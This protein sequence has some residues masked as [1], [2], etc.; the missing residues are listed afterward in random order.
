MKKLILF[1][2]AA[3]LFA[4]CSSDNDLVQQEQPQATQAS[5]A[6]SFNAYLQR[7]TTTRAGWVGGATSSGLQSIS[8]L[9]AEGFGVFAYYT[10]NFDYT[11]LYLPNF[12][13]NEKV[14]WST[15]P[16]PGEFR[17][18]TTKYW[19]N[20]HGSAAKSVDQDR[21]SFFA[22]LPY[23]DTDP[24]TGF[25]KNVDT[26]DPSQQWGITGMKRNSM[27][28]D[29]VIQ[30]ITSFDQDKSV[31]LCWGTTG[32][33]N[34]TWS[35]NS[36]TQTIT[37]GKPWLN[38]RKP[39]GVV[40]NNSKVNFTFLHA[41]SKFRVTVQTDNTDS[42]IATDEA[43]ATRVWIRSI[44]FTGIA[45]KAALNLNNPVANK[46]R[47]IDYYGS[48][49]LEMGESVTVYDGRKDG[50][51]GV[52]G[53]E[54]VSETVLGLNPNLIQDEKQLTSSG[55]L[56][57]GT[58]YHTGVPSTTA[59]NLFCNGTDPADVDD[60]IFVIPT[61]EKVDVEIVYD[62]ETIDEKLPVYLSDS[63]THGSSV[64][65]RIT[66]KSVFA[67]L[68]NGKSYVLNLK[69]G[70]KDV[71]FDAQVIQ[72]WETDITE[73][74]YLPS[75][76][77][78]YAFTATGSTLEIPGAA[79]GF[80]F[81]VTGLKSGEGV[82]TSLKDPPT[83]TCLESA[84]SQ[85]SSAFNGSANNKASNGGNVFVKVT[86]VTQ[87]KTVNNKEL[88]DA[89]TVDPAITTGDPFKLKLIQKAEALGLAAPA[90]P[91]AGT[92]FTLTRSITGSTEWSTA[93]CPA[94]IGY[95]G[96]AGNNYIRVWRGS[97][98]LN[99]HS[100]PSAA[101][102]FKF[103]N[104]SG[105]ITLQTGAVSGETITVTIKAGDALEETKSFPIP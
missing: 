95:P 20:E 22:Y 92:T 37:A 98:E 25:V 96:T 72:N 32:S 35:T 66:K 101:N 47:W 61:G 77:P 93:E 68:E 33:T 29:P 10:D 11:P 70:M 52:V 6:V 105:I 21:V 40:G 54:S 90:S 83:G 41:T 46:A 99:Y 8:D 71:K 5:D 57:S 88:A 97:T 75:N 86:N 69:L 45:K 12:M 64:E 74:V 67:K 94:L 55:W 19:P 38:V 85:T 62:I 91:T 15:T 51:E 39:D 14:T 28:G 27:Q 81:V 1:A 89:V 4:A 84:S 48:N 26:S 63:E 53:A 65:N 24:S 43:D 103:D 76:V 60:A 78:S 87:N 18:T 16:V 30:Y 3:A 73:D 58:D 42:W 36:A 13:Y 80:D 50:S 34:I 82:A 102:E 44:R 104:S 100:S 23:V 79:T 49:E 9:G 17:Y 2:A 59:V 56:T 7:S 31:D